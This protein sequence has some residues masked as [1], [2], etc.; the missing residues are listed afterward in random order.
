MLKL[1]PNYVTDEDNNKI[2]VQLS[3]KMYKKIEEALENYGLSKLMEDDTE[4]PL[5]LNEANAF[6]K[7][8]KKKK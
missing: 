1:H 2:A 6:Y 7:K 3:I 8:L 4:K 5:E